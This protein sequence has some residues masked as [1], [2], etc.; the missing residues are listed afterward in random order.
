VEVDV[1]DARLRVEGGARPA[2]WRVGV[3]ATFRV[4]RGVRLAYDAPGAVGV[5][6]EW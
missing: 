6:F 2:G 4:A 5:S 1:G 3:G